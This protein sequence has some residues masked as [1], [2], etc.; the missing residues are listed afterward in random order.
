MSVSV[1]YIKI[2][3]NEIEVCCLIHNLK[4]IRTYPFYNNTIGMTNLYYLLN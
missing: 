4:I 2:L 1:Y 3:N